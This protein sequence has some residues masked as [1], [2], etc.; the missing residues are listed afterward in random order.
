MAKWSP[1]DER[2]YEHIKESAQKRGQSRRAKEIAA[3]TVN[4]QRREE[5]STENAASS[6]KSTTTS[7][8]TSGNGRGQST[9]RAS[10]SRSTS[11]NGN[12][13]EQTRQQLYERA[14]K[15]KIEGRSHM[16]KSQ[17]VRAIQKQK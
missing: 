14:R 9:T 11:G 1:K 10:A 7:R 15:M 6:R 3:R 13:K 17:L 12:L 5:G 2:Q 8:S 4:K 16:N